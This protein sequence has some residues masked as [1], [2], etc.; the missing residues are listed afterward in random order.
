MRRHAA[1]IRTSLT[2]LTFGLLFLLTSPLEGFAA[3]PTRDAA[4]CTSLGLSC[5]PEGQPYA[6]ARCNTD[7]N[8]IFCEDF[9][10]PQDFVCVPFDLSGN[11]QQVWRNPGLTTDGQSIKFQ[12]CYAA[13]FPAA[14]GLPRTLD[15][16][17]GAGNVYRA[18]PVLGAA[19]ASYVGCILGDCDRN[20]ADSPST[21]PNGSAATN[22]LYFRFQIYNAGGSIDGDGVGGVDPEWYWPEAIDNKILFL[23]PN[24]YSSKDSANVDAGLYFNST[25]RCNPEVGGMRYNDAVSFRIGTNSDNFKFY[26]AYLNAVTSPPHT[27]YCS[28]M[29][30][31]NGT[32]DD[33]TVPVVSGYPPS[34]NPDPGTLF[35]MKTGRWYTLEFR[36]KLSLPGQPNGTVELWIDGV[37]VYSDSDL[38]TC[39]NYGASEGSCY[40]LHEI[41]LEGSWYN[42]NQ[43]AIDLLAAQRRGSYRLI[44]NFII[45]KSYI[46]VPGAD[47]SVPTAPQNLKAT[48]V[49]TLERTNEGRTAISI[50]FTPEAGSEYY[51]YKNGLYYTKVTGSSYRDMWVKSGEPQ[52]YELVEYRAGKPVGAEKFSVA[53]SHHRRAVLVPTTP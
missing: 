27:E 49:A 12:F 44:D 34:G 47:T 21:Y 31:L 26:P 45:S 4:W 52:N 10:Y 7:P 20:T 9:N 8:I 24:R 19:A 5:P 30:S 18:R 3:A 2:L 25:G 11:Y 46:G 36:Y 40:A 28:G 13:D 39:G 14:S 50:S 22:D 16:P 23:Y 37:K 38:E 42:P 15:N 35:R 33:G 29:G 51:L 32:K 6:E 48:P 53:T 43:P 1:I 17:A 41:F